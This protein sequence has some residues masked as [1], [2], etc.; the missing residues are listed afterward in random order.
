MARGRVGEMAP[1]VRVIRR[2]HQARRRAWRTRRRWHDNGRTSFTAWDCSCI[3]QQVMARGELR[4]K[5]P[6]TESEAQPE[7]T[8][9][10]DVDEPSSLDSPPSAWVP[11]EVTRTSPAARLS[12]GDRQD[13]V[14]AD[15]EPQPAGPVDADDDEAEA[16]SGTRSG[17][18]RRVLVGVLALGDR[19]G[20]RRRWPRSGR[21]IGVSVPP[22]GPPEGGASARSPPPLPGRSPAR[23]GIV[24]RLMGRSGAGRRRAGAPQ[25]CP[26]GPFGCEE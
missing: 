12:R 4:E 7:P 1:I 13:P 11:S 6:E 2:G 10:A 8:R 19:R 20:L 26:E 18:P 16:G 21:P 24:S 9:A 3:A 25:G 22:G 15:P 17:P 14:A 23:M 5:S